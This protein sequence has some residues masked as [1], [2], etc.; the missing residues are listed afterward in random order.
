[1]SS[2]IIVARLVR[3]PPAFCRENLCVHPSNGTRDLHLPCHRRLS[4]P[5]RK[6]PS[7]Q[8]LLVRH[9][10]RGKPLRKWSSPMSDGWIL[11]ISEKLSV[12]KWIIHKKVDKL[13]FIS[14]FSWRVSCTALVNFV[15]ASTGSNNDVSFPALSSSWKLP[16]KKDRSSLNFLI[17]RYVISSPVDFIPSLQ[18]LVFSCN[19]FW[20]FF[21]KLHETLVSATLCVISLSPFSP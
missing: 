2:V 9:F 1:M 4:S 16:D 21:S 20:N 13:L 3:V 12:N 15:R 10:T 18:K 19:F 6:S 8:L 7:R 11:S 17:A 5:G 14:F